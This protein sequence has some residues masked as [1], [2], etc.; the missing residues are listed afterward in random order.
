[1]NLL[2]IRHEELDPERNFTVAGERAEHIRNVLRAKPGDSVKTGLL[3]GKIGTS[4]IV[5]IEKEKAVLHAGSFET[6][7]PVPLSLSLVTALPRP[8]TFKKTLHFAVSSGIRKI[9]FIQSVRVEKSYWKSPVLAQDS[10]N[11]EIR[12]ALE[13]GVDT[14][15]PELHFF[16]TFKEFLDAE[17]SL[18]PENSIRLI[19]HPGEKPRKESLKGKHIVLAIGPEGGF[20]RT[21]IEAFAQCGWQPAGFGAHILRTEFAAAFITG[22]LEGMR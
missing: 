18:F 8:Q 11:K 13:Q 1:M 21:E 19:A 15:P 9:V 6:D 22:Y 10:I 5:S 16:R 12:E 7:P 4:T 2:L 14:I 20:V 3:G 17:K